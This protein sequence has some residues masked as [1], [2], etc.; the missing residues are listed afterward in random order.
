MIEDIFP[1]TKSKLK[2]LNYIY[3]N[4]GTN[5]TELVKGTNTSP[6][7]VVKY[8]NKLVKFKV[9]KENTSGG[10]KKPHIRKIS[11]HLDSETGKLIF[12]FLEIDK[13][14]Y[15]LKK[16]RKFTPITDQLE[17]LFKESRVKFCLVYGSFARFSPTKESDVDVLIVGNL[18]SENRKRI[19]EIFTT[20]GREYS[21]QIEDYKT[22][23]K[24]INNS[25]HQNILRHHV[26]LWNEFEYIK[27]ISS[28]SSPT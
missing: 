10:E 5:I 25:F 8:V 28:P 23:L 16:Y 6:N 9:V 24:K 1:S 2:I 12:T 18:N 13:K 7:L 27:T 19:S 11:P 22:F 15:F 14:H 17:N 21:L 20:L 3:K 26:V 4:P